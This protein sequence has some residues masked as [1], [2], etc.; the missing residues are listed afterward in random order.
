MLKISRADITGSHLVDYGA[1]RF[2]KLP[3]E[4]YMKLMPS[5]VPSLE[6]RTVFDDLNAPQIAL[7][8]A[9]NSPS[10]RFVCA[11]L[12]RRLGKTFIANIVGQMV[13]LVPGCNVLIMSPNYALSTISFE[14][15]RKFIRQFDLE[16]ERDNVKD[17]VLELSNGSTIRMGSVGQ[18]DSSVGR[19]YNLIIFDEAALSEKG[20]EAFNISLRPT[21]DRP[22]S[23]A[24]FISTPRGKKNW[25]S[26]FYNRGFSLELKEWCSIHADY[27]ENPR[28]TAADVAEAKQT[29]SAAE[30][31]QEYMA[32]FNSFQGQIYTI[33]EQNVI[34]EL[35]LGKYE[36]F[37]G[38]DPGYKDPTAFVV[39]AYNIEENWYCVIDEYLEAERVTNQH[40]A[41]INEIIKRHSIETIFIDSAAAQFGA[42]LA[43]NYDIATIKANKAVLEGI[44]Y[45]QSI[46][47][48]DRL[49]VLSHCQNTLDALDQYRWDDS[50]TLVKERPKHDKHSHIADAL[51]YALYSFTI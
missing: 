19:S 13:V 7:I 21:L 40:A 44:A 30:F 36:I 4:S 49:Y 35:P 38:L 25:F 23:K 18:V 3:I 27:H 10:Y 47:Q 6:P 39:I 29:M 31:E 22:G 41:A 51:R 14:L 16:L 43:Y 2:I 48:Q 20:E 24:I 5:P 45:G 34:Q 17:R 46:V 15:Q 42:D 1:G 37:A 28:M 33:S 12:S 8:N 9:V 11:A 50:E 26:T 32:S